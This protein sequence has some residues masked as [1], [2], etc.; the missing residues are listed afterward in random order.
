MRLLPAMLVGSAVA[1]LLSSRPAVAQ[2]ADNFI[3]VWKLNVTKSKYTSGGA[4]P[5]EL[6]VTFEKVGTT[7]V[8]ITAKGTNADGSAIN[9]VYTPTYDGKDVPVTGSP[10]YDAASLKMMDS[11]TR[12]TV[13]K[14]AGKEVQVVHSVVSKDGKS[15]TSTTTGVNAKG[16]KV[17]STAIFE[18]Q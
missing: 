14:K 3:G 2:T 18:K 8:K 4:T 15:F 12:H 1:G 11:N 16:E 5:K 10:D 7:G 9:T 6:T 13:R 17:N